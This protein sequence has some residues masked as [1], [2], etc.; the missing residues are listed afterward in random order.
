MSGDAGCCTA[1]T[2]PHTRVQD[3]NAIEKRYKFGEVLGSGSF[4]VVR[5][6]THPS[7]KQRFAVKIVQKDKVR[8]TREF[9]SPLRLTLAFGA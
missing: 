6:A 4:G 9:L 1:D 7:T 2:R 5:L 8:S 3:E